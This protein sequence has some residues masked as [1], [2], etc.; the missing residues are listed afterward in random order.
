MFGPWRDPDHDNGIGTTH[1]ALDALRAAGPRAAALGCRT[2]SSVPM[3]E[4]SA[5]ARLFE[6]DIPE[7]DDEAADLDLDD[8]L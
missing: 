5:R 4:V 2:L 7:Y 1:R 8:L 6:K 3:V